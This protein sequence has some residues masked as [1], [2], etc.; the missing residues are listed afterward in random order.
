MLNLENTKLLFDN[1]YLY[2]AFNILNFF[3]KIGFIKIDILLN[4]KK[5]KNKINIIKFLHRIF[6]F[7]KLLFNL[8][9]LLIGL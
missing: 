7:K 2:G 8:E 9:V 4:L 3:L 6:F 1:L 5:F